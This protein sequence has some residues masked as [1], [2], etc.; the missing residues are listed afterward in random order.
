[1]KLKASTQ[2]LKHHRLCI[3]HAP[4][5]D[6]TVHSPRYELSVAED[7]PGNPTTAATTLGLPSVTVPPNAVG[8]NSSAVAPTGTEALR[9]SPLV[10][11]SHRHDIAASPSGVELLALAAVSFASELL[12]N[13]QTG[14]G[15][16]NEPPP[17]PSPLLLCEE[18]ASGRR[19]EG[20][21]SKRRHP[22]PEPS[23][24]SRMPATCS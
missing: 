8:R 4:A 19:T 11:P 14:R 17:P 9:D 18:E 7:R 20:S 16:C 24:G 3:H 12:G 5:R 23:R 15:D 2:E 22:R 6:H 1:M 13:A 21:S 10:R